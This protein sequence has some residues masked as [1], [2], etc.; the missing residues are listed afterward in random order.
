MPIEFSRQEYWSGVTFPTPWDL[1]ILGTEPESLESL[2]LAGGFFTET[3][4]WEVSN[5]TYCY[6]TPKFQ[7]TRKK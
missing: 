5:E 1:S 7:V 3:A 6:Y 4:T 2:E